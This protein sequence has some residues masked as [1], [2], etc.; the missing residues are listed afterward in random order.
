MYSD[1][2][3][4]WDIQPWS[5]EEDPQAES[6]A[7][8]HNRLKWPT[9]ATVGHGDEVLEVHF[10]EGANSVFP[11]A[12]A[13]SLSAA[14]CVLTLTTHG[15][16]G[17]SLASPSFVRRLLKV[18]SDVFGGPVLEL[19]LPDEAAARAL[20]IRPFLDEL[21]EARTVESVGRYQWLAELRSQDEFARVVDRVVGSGQD[22]RI[23]FGEICF[24]DHDATAL[25]LAGPPDAVGEA[26]SCVGQLAVE[27]G[28]MLRPLRLP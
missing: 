13:D 28:F 1:R 12:F 19:R 26:L 3:I 23:Q 25:F 18:L 7:V 17:H 20:E 4:E 11:R 2:Y 21:T 22:Y 24:A 27:E 10:E 6:D 8:V 9:D 15:F 5:P 16:T 14:D